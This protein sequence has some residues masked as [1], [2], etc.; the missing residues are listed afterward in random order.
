MRGGAY[1]VT[2]ETPDGSIF[3]PGQTANGY[4]GGSI[5]FSS[6]HV[7]TSEIGIIE[8]LAENALG[9]Q[10]LHEHPLHRVFREVRIYGLAAQSI[11]IFE[12]ADERGIALFLFVD[13]LFDR[14]R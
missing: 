7:A 3:H 4:L 11:K 9:K 13:C 8:N 12:A 2:V 6:D 10:M 1:N 14:C 5:N